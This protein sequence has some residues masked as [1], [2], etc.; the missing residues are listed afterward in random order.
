VSNNNLEAKRSL[1][2]DAQAYDNIQLSRNE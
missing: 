2:I 1:K